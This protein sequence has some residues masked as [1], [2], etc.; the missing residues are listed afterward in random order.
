MATKDNKMHIERENLP[1]L[2]KV[3][4]VSDVAHGPRGFFPRMV[5]PSTYKTNRF[6]PY[7][8]TLR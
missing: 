5:T 2:A 8:L 6:I 1:V 3:T 7:H 4:Q